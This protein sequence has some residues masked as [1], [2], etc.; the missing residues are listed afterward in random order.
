M[1][2]ERRLVVG[3]IAIAALGTLAGCGPVVALVA[4]GGAVGGVVGAS[5]G[6]GGGHGG[7]APG[8]ETP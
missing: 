4:I 1:S 8:G 5:G 3:A 7:G 2:S 6:G